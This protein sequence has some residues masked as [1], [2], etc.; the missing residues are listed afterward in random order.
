MEGRCLKVFIFQFVGVERH[1]GKTWNIVQLIRAFRSKGLRV[2]VVKHAHGYDPSFDLKSET[3][4]KDTL[5]F[6]DA[7][8]VAAVAVTEQLTATLTDAKSLDEVVRSLMPLV[9][10][11]FL[12]GFREIGGYPRVIVA[13]SVEE[14]TSLISDK[15]LA[16]TGSVAETSFDE[17]KELYPTVTVARNVNELVTVLYEFMVEEVARRVGGKGCGVCGYHNC[18]EFIR[19]LRAGGAKPTMCPQISPRVMIYLDGERLSINPFVQSIFEN[20]L[21]GVL[22]TLKGV[23]NPK[24]IEI[25]INSF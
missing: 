18:E 11:V 21:K 17:I 10:V 1:T 22:K 8:A 20:V 15:V 2:G 14:V 6:M 25:I 12:E 3:A 23:G 4:G 9:D 24:R 19:A 7:G 16:V 5:R 13:N